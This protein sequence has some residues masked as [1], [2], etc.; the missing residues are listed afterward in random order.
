MRSGFGWLLSSLL[1]VRQSDF[2][3]GKEDDVAVVGYLPEWRYEGANWETLSE[4]LTHLLLF[5]LEPD[6]KGRILAWD[7]FPRRDL[8]NEARQAAKRH[9]T[10]L[11]ICFG[12]NGRSAG[13]SAMVRKRKARARFLKALE[14]FLDQEQLDGVDYNWEYP[15]YSFRGGYQAEEEIKADYMG[16]FKLINETKAMFRE[17]SP[18]RVVTMAYYPDTRQEQLL[19][20]YRIDEEVDLMHM[21]SYDQNGAHHSTLQFGKKA[22]DQGVKVL[23]PRKLTMGVPFYGR[24]TKTG[25]WTTYEDLVQRHEPLDAKMDTV[26]AP[27]KKGSIGFNGVKTIEAKT[28]YAIEKGTGGVMIWEAGQ[29]CRLVPVVHG[30]KTHVRT[31]PSD[32]AS[33]LRAIS[34]AIAAAGKQRMR[35]DGWTPEAAATTPKGDEL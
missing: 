9:G 18:M 19:K 28:K 17:R 3:A 4:H 14:T 11:L 7:R 21:M 34:R 32:D 10:K 25:D 35:A 29:D 27:D 31:C 22:V 24:H 12:G 1:L 13:F 8:M 6:P 26:D 15:G 20:Q 5:S 30:K 23:P 33:L 16:L 2:A